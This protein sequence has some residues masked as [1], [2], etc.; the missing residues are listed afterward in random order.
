MNA[1]WKN[2]P[3]LAQGLL[4]NGGY[5]GGR[6]PTETTEN[7]AARTAPANQRRNEPVRRGVSAPAAACR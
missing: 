7:V 2:L 5:L 3:H 6:F 1:F 4:A